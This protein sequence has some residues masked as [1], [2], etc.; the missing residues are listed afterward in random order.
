M[1]L[2]ATL[3]FVCIGAVLAGCGGMPK[4]EI[5][6]VAPRADATHVRAVLAA[7]NYDESWDKE[8]LRLRCHQI[9][10]NDDG[11]PTNKE[12]VFE[13]GYN[14]H[15]GARRGTLKMKEADGDSTSRVRLG[16]ELVSGENAAT[17]NISA[18]TT[19]E[20]NLSS[21]YNNKDIVFVAVI[22]RKTKNNY[23]IDVL[24]A[25][26]PETGELEQVLPS[27]DEE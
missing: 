26:N 6:S 24:Y 18:G 11:V 14:D 9:W 3:F 22:S 25:L 19:I 13:A 2:L 7:T 15:A 10:L 20:W 1:R 27:N 8:N 5:E 21:S 4:P 17:E 23:K 16:F 12:Q